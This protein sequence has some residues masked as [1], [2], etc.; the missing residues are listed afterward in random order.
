MEG[1]LATDTVEM[2]LRFRESW[3]FGPIFS[4]MLVSKLYFLYEVSITF[5][6]ACEETTRVF[7]N[8]FPISSKQVAE[9]IQ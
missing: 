2:Y 7:K 5:V 6:E 1:V 8:D 9:V 4:R 3:L